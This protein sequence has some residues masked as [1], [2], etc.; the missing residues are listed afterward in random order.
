MKKNYL[1]AFELAEAEYENIRNDPDDIQR[2]SDTTGKDIDIISRVKTHIFYAEHDI[3]YQDGSVVR[4]RLDE[5]PEI[6]NSW[7]RLREDCC[8]Q[9][10]HDFIAHEERESYLVIFQGMGYNEAHKLTISEGLTW[11]PGGE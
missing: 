9:S 7:V 5:D 2:I 1:L 10:D 11:C 4:K 3:T 8:I 6:V